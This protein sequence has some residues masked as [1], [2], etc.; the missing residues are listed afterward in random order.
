MA[1]G[2]GPRR[3]LAR[4]GHWALARAGHWALALGKQGMG[5]GLAP[6]PHHA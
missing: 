2:I 1:W 6:I 3:A 4:A 5:I